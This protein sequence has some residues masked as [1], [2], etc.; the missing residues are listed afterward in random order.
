[1]KSKFSILAALL[2]SITLPACVQVQSEVK[3]ENK[4]LA[5]SSVRD[6]PLTYAKGSTFSLLPHYAKQSSLNAKQTQ[7]VYALYNDTINK[8]LQE[9]GYQT[10]EKNQP[11]AFHV[12][13]GIALS[14][15]FSDEN[16]NEKFGVLPGLQDK[17]SLQKGSFLIY[18]EDTASGAIIWRGA[19]QG[20]AHEQLSVEQRKQR[21]ISIVASVMQQFYQ[22]K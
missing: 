14:S 5:I 10:A 7:T 22:T 13:F 9:N 16:I 15:D 11:V 4:Q 20:F 1:M 3:R 2:I 6:A 17:Q 18:I 8:N 21:T 12:G 19:V